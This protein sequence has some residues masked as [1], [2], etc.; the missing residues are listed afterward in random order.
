[1]FV[2]ELQLFYRVEEWKKDDGEKV[3]GVKDNIVQ[4]TK[5]EGYFIIYINM[6]EREN[7]SERGLL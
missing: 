7:E 4:L 5:R 3:L 6:A 1:M 2:F